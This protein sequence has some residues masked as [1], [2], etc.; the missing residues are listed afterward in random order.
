MHIYNN[1]VKLTSTMK[2]NKISNINIG[3]KITFYKMFNNRSL[4]CKLKSKLDKIV[5]NFKRDTD[6]KKINL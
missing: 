1:I 2:I 6:N 3:V 5:G 4:S